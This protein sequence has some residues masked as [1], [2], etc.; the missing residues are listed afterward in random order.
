MPDSVQRLLEVYVV[1]EQ[2]PLMLLLVLV[3]GDYR[4][5]VETVLWPGLKPACLPAS[6][7]SALVLNRL[8]VTPSTVLLEWLIRLMVR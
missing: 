3:Y 7:S 1:V 4:R 2:N 8:T 5:S 6:N